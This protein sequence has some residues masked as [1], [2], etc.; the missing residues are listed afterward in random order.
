[1][2]KEENKALVRKVIE[3][4]NN[5]DLAVLDK[6]IAPTYVNQTY[7]LRGPE[8]YKQLLT[9]IFKAF[10]DWHETV[11]DIVAEGDK[12][13]VR[14]QIDTG[15]HTGELNLLGVSV[16]P[17]GKKSIVKSI[18]IWRIGDG[19]VVEQESVYDELDFLRQLG[20]IYRKRNNTLSR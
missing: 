17:T 3:G 19:R 16:S 1:V 11:E 15:I 14:L 6:L 9:V 20:L 18:Q 8:G 7:Q 5:R 13:C 12:V 10:P 4:E 2:S